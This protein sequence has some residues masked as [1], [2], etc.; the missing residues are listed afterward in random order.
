MSEE[1]NRRDIDAAIAWYAPDA[2]WDAS[3]AGAGVFEGRDAIRSF[4][5]DWHGSYEDFEEVLEEFR[6]LGNN[7]TLGVISM[8][9]RMRGGSGVLAERHAIVWTWREGLIERATV[10]GPDIDQAR[11]AAERLAKERG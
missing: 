4:F 2:V 6:I 11:A 5:E 1:S 7:V 3:P 8:R 10:Y 9:G